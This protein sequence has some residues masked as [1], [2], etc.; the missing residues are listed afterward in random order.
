MSALDDDKVAAALWEGA[1]PLAELLDEVATVF[2]RFVVLSD[3]Q[4]VVM[5]LWVA[6]THAFDAAETTPYV[7]VTSAEKRSGKTRLQD[8]AEPLVHKPWKTGR[9]TVAVLTRKVAKERPT[10]LLD[11]LDAAFK[12]GDEYGQALRGILN[13][14][15]QKGGMTSVCVGQGASIDYADL[16]V[17]SPKCFAMIGELPDTIADR[18]IRIELKRRNRTEQVG[19]FRRRE[20]RAELEK[21]RD[22]LASWASEDVIEKLADARPELPDELHD[23]AQDVWEPLLAIGELAGEWWAQKARAAAIGLADS[24]MGADDSLGVACLQ[25]AQAAFAERDTD[26]LATAELAAFLAQHDEAAFGDL[27]YEGAQQKG[28]GRRIAK[29]LK[30]FDIRPQTIRRADGT[31][32]KGYKIEAFEDAF[33]RYLTSHP[34]HPSHP[35][36]SKGNTGSGNRYGDPPVTDTKTPENP[37]TT[38]DVTDVTDTGAPSGAQE[39][40]FETHRGAYE[41]SQ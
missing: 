21:L 15:F 2:Q 41:G 29:W 1:P 27:V 39:Q 5:A 30:P 3:K 4:A 9:V 19:R 17:F 7:H 33:S 11:E 6:H 32:L 35:I 18:S 31:S 10:L 36:P 28:A 26:R 23:R 24:D 12:S 22:E 13:V 8:V 25:G 14:G 40:F 34:S 20:H 38:G 37:V 16:E